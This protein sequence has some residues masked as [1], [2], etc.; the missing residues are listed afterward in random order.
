MDG[1]ITSLDGKFKLSILFD[2]GLFNQICD[3]F[4][5]LKSQKNGFTN[6][7]IIL[8]KSVVNKNENN[9]YYNI[10]FKKGS[11]KD[12]WMFVYY[13]YYIMIELMF[14]KEL[15]LIKPV[16]QKSVIFVA[17]SISSI[18]V[19]SFNKISAIDLMIY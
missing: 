12:K 14:L 15:M 1:F 2:Y 19:L 8:N 13:K 10:F 7:I 4:K 6:S 11:Y 5:Y 18:I 3:K 9:Y 17:I 16:H